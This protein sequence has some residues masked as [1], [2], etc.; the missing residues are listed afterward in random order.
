[1][2]FL[3]RPTLIEFYTRYPDSKAA[4]EALYKGIMKSSPGNLLELQ[5]IVKSAEAVG[6]TTVINIKGNKYRLIAAINYQYQIF[7]CLEI[8]THAEYSKETWKERHQ[9]FD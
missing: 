4:L 8:M 1:M 6:R 5:K 3:S 9:V 7:Y 2:R